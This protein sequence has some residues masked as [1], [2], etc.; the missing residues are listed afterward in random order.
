MA[1]RVVVEGAIAFDIAF[2]SLVCAGPGPITFATARINFEIP[3]RFAQ[4]LRN[5]SKGINW[6]IKT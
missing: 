2:K 3:V 4:L 6:K 5:M 1:S